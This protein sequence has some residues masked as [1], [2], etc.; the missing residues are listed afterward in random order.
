MPWKKA[1]VEVVAI[2]LVVVACAS[3]PPVDPEASGPPDGVDYT[4][5]IQCA[6][7]GNAI[8]TFQPGQGSFGDGSRLGVRYAVWAQHVSGADWA[9]VRADIETSRKD[10]VR[11]AGDGMNRARVARLERDYAGALNV[12]RTLA[13]LPELIFIGG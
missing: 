5:A 8:K 1:C 2:A 4:M 6:G 7:L 9:V 11:E 12:C 13:D 3:P 10:F